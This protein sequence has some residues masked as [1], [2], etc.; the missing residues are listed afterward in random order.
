MTFRPRTF[1]LATAVACGLA[2]LAHSQNEMAPAA[3]APAPAAAAAEPA[4]APADAPAPTDP[5]GPAVSG[6]SAIEEFSPEEVEK[7]SYTIGFMLG[8]QYR[9]RFELQLKP[10]AV[11]EGLRAGLS[12]EQPKLSQEQI[13]QTMSRFEQTMQ[14]KQM[15]KFQEQAAKGDTY[16]TE[17]KTKEGVKSTESGLQYQVLTEGKGDSPKPDDTVRVHYR[18]TLVDGTQFDSSYD[19]QEPAE[20]K[21]NE[22]IA[23]WTEALQLMKP[24][25]KY[26][27]VIPSDLAYGDE[28][29]PP[30]IPPKSV[31]VFDVELL[32]IVK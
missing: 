15:A 20:F 17:N 1:L 2:P 31:L 22:V 23:G 25:A 6:P 26:R 28:G 29:R 24:G 5:N 19:R 27:L 32:D 10:E 8:S 21:V 9:Q 12:G 4:P 7:L 13:Q 30:V 3:E 14:L 11:D 18:G 16:L